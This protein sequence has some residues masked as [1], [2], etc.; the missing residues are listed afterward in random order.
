MCRCVCVCVCVYARRNY[1]RIDGLAGNGDRRQLV[2]RCGSGERQQG[3]E[4][5]R[6]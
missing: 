2:L 6:T 3:I 5:R 4:L 1:V